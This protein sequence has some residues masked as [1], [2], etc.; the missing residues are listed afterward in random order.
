MKATRFLYITGGELNDIQYQLY[1]TFFKFAQQPNTF[2]DIGKLQ[3]ANELHVEL[4][5]SINNVERIENFGINY[6]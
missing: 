6:K 1:Q 2:K 4:L 5:K 3:E